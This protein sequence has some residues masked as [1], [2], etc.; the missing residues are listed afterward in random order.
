MF[1]GYPATS[2]FEV[3]HYITVFVCHLDRDLSLFLTGMDG[4]EQ[5]VDGSVSAGDRRRRGNEDPMPKQ[6]TNKGLAKRFG[7]TKNGKVKRTKAFR[8]HLMGTKNAKRRRRLR[9]AAYL[10]PGD[11]RRVKKLLGVA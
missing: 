4:I 10:I 6:K 8:G 2:V 3:N 9:R 1:F 5:K 7:L 11:A